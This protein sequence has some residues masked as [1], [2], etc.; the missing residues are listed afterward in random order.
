ME[1]TTWN[2][3]AEF[4]A[5]V[6]MDSSPTLPSLFVAGQ[7]LTPKDAQRIAKNVT[8]GDFSLKRTMPV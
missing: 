5:A 6:S 2:S 1:F 4:T 3:T 7:Q 8:G